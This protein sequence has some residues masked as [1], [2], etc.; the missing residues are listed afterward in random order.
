MNIKGTENWLKSVD[1]LLTTLTNLL[2]KHW[3]ILIILSILA[4]GY[5]VWT[6]EE[7]VVE[8]VETEQVE[9]DGEL[10]TDEEVMDEEDAF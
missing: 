3:L 10:Q 5:Y 8:S 2:K 1:S 4:L 6:F 9:T 7:A